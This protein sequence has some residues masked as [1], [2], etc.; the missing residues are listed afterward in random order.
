MAIPAAVLA[1]VMAL[2]APL[3][4]AEPGPASIIRALK[5]GDAAKKGMALEYIGK[6]HPENLLSLLI[7]LA[8]KT[9]NKEHRRTALD[10]IQLYPRETSLPALA[11]VLEKTAS[12]DLKIELIEEL[13]RFTDR[14]LFLPIAGHLK[15]PS[16]P[17]R[18]AAAKALKQADDRIYPI[19]LEMAE[20]DN[21]ALKLYALQAF[22]HL[23]DRRFY[24]IVMNLLNDT[25]KS[26]RIYALDCIGG[27]S[28]NQAGPKVRDMAL[29]DAN[30]EVR[31]EAVKALG[32]LGDRSM[33]STLHYLLNDPVQDV[34][35]QAVLAI[36]SLGQRSSSSSPLSER[37]ARENNDDIKKTII[38][39]LINFKNAGTMTGLKKVLLED[40]NVLL[41]I[42]AA[43][44]LGYISDS[45][46][47]APLI[48][49]LGD[50]D[51]RVRA[52]ASSS[53]GNFRNRAATEPLLAVV[54][55]DSDRYARSAALYALK[56]INDRKAVIPLY[57]LYALEKDPVFKEQLRSV[58]RAFLERLT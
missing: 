6:N 11:G 41:R 12:P 19:V 2:T 51:Y 49:A 17:V 46:G 20:S 26:I 43:C 28:L 44:A 31:V 56:K 15:H 48:S 23:Y 1:V 40:R 13:S 9:G 38:N 21:P 50:G 54:A 4:A 18:E 25:N 14:R 24:G 53:L 39:V 37:L 35:F 45:R 10:A 55:A 8:A 22:K 42:S 33:L 34:R 5:Q 16:M 32:T 30:D 3:S 58:I 57:D 47:L 36:D 27:N 52:E 7:S 29:R